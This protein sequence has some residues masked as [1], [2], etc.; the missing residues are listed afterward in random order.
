M[1]LPSGFESST[2]YLPP[3]YASMM[4][5]S[6]PGKVPSDRWRSVTGLTRECRGSIGHLKRVYPRSAVG[7]LAGHRPDA[8]NSV[9]QARKSSLSY[10]NGRSVLMR[11]APLIDWRARQIAESEMRGSSARTH[12]LAHVATWSLEYR[13]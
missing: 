4:Y 3:E 9:S 7:W 13:P 10:R 12:C 1:V 2:S 8:L 11:S 6:I 5:P